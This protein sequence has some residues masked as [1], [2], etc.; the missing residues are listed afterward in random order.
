MN[1]LTVKAMYRLR[2]AA[3]CLLAC[4]VVS[5]LGAGCARSTLPLTNLTMPLPATSLN[6]ESVLEVFGNYREGNFQN[7]SWTDAFLGMH[8]KLSREYPF[9]EWKGVDWDALYGTCAPRVEAASQAK[10]EAAYYLALR[11][12]L[13]SI[14]DAGLGISTPDAYRDAAIGAGFGFSMLPLDDGRVVVVRVEPGFF[15][16]MAGIA[17]GAEII[18][19]NGLPI[20]EALEQASFLW[21]DAP[22]ATD[23]NRLFE[24]CALLTRAPAGTKATLKFRNPGSDEVWITQLEARRDFYRSLEDLTRQDKTITEFDSPLETR[25]LDG[26]IGYIKIYCHAATLAMPF[27]ARAFR[28]AMEQFLKANVAGLVLD[29]RGDVGGL[30]QLAVTYAGHFTREPLFYRNV[31]AFDYDKG[32]F[33]LKEDASMTIEPRAPYFGGPVM[34]L[35]QHTTR[36]SGQALADSLHQLPNVALMGLTGTDGSWS[37]PGGQVTIPGGHV[38]T[39]PIGRFLDSADTIRVTSSGKMESRVKPDIRVPLTLEAYEAF[40]KEDRDEVLEQ[41]IEEIKAR[42]AAKAA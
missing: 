18:A 29:L 10:D 13:Y 33:A 19:W 30:D 3:L 28:N 16:D 25:I 1:I 32:G 34:V 35:I 40:F 26:N 15:A 31:V 41:A 20:G 21:S 12:Y 11:S 38:I 22:P 37:L 8:Q 36:D 39:Y 6:M 42:A 17:W 9:S 27:P 7:R 5:G 2:A 24:Q 14:P 23:E 4:G